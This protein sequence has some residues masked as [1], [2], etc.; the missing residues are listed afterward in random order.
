[1]GNMSILTYQ[2]IRR[3]LAPGLLACALTAGCSGEPP[4][5]T[6][7]AVAVAESSGLLLPPGYKVVDLPTETRRAI[8]AEAHNIRSLAVQEANHKLPVD[9]AHLPKG[10]TAAFEKRRDD[11]MEIIKAAEA[12]DLGVLAAKHKIAVAD[13]VR[14]EDEASRLRWIP[15]Q[16]PVYEAPD[17]KPGGEPKASGKGS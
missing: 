13:I 4:A 7:N 15:P 5:P 16:E 9:E 6:G 14:I 3:S 11:H 8:F 10:D 12:R 1:M 2:G 17:G